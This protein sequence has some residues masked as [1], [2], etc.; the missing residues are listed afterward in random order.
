MRAGEAYHK[1]PDNVINGVA[2]S[3]PVS[4]SG[5]LHHQGEGLFGQAAAVATNLVA[6]RLFREAR[7]SLD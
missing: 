2:S 4:N 5:D 1:E 6:F 3:Y 7:L